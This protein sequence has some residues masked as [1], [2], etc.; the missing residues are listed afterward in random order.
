MARLA[1]NWWHRGFDI[2]GNRTPVFQPRASL[3]NT[4]GNVAV[5]IWLIW[6]IKSRNAG[7]SSTTMN[8]QWTDRQHI[9]VSKAGCRLG[10]RRGT[11]WCGDRCVTV[12]TNNNRSIDIA[13]LS[14]VNIT[15][16]RHLSYDIKDSS[17]IFGEK[18]WYKQRSLW[19]ADHVWDITLSELI[20]HCVI[21]GSLQS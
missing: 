2:T 9:Q 11:T 18:L 17:I 1:R 10:N 12:T 20:T 21:I 8:Q 5:P 3:S 15:F 14:H 13:V 7:R 19:Q 4:I 16:Y 6:G